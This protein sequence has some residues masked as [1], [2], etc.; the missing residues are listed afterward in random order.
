MGH[1]EGL[2]KKLLIT[3]FAFKKDWID[4]W[5]TRN[6]NFTDKA[7]KEYLEKELI[8]Y[9]LQEIDNAVRSGRSLNDHFKL[10]NQ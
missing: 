2:S 7:A 8:P 5:K 10:L 9:L 6:I 1:E 4:L 3:G